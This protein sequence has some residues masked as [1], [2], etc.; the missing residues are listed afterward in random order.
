MFGNHFHKHGN[1]S[2]ESISIYLNLQ[3]LRRFSF[4]LKFVQDS[5]KP[6]IEVL[7]FSFE[8]MVAMKSSSIKDLV[9]VSSVNLSKKS[10]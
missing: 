1:G 5:G 8:I 2:R 9:V 10:F 3:L 7:T 4:G 6:L